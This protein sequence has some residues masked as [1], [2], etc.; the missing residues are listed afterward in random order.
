MAPSED[1]VA[2]AIGEIAAAY[3]A[4]PQVRAVALAGSRAQDSND[5][6]SDVDLYLYADAPVPLEARRAII[7]PRAAADPPPEIGSKIWEEEDDWIEPGGLAI[8]VIHRTSA[9]IEDELDRVLVRHEPRLG[10][11]TCFWHSVRVARVL[12][13]RDGWFSELRERAQGTYPEP[14]ARAII[15]LN[16]PVLREVLPSYAHQITQ[17]AAR[18]DRLA[19]H[20]RVAVFLASYFDVLFAVN[21]T[22]HP[23]EKRLLDHAAA[24]ERVPAR[25]RAKISG[26]LEDAAVAPNRL[27]PRIEA[28]CDDLDALVARHAPEAQSAAA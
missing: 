6:R 25:L 15:G 21:R 24:L 14:L 1:E 16:R 19:V 13:D 2:R 8:E 3:A 27:A 20:H 22:T 17:A 9:W 28:L 23:G 7:L 11:S 4:L 12:H 18:D 26:L 5:A 10:Y